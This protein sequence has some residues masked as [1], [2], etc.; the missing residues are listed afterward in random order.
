MAK[1]DYHY[2]VFKILTYLYSVI[3]REQSFDDMIFKK[4]I[5]TYD[6]K[7]EY[8]IDVLRM[9]SD[10]NLIKG[11]KFCNAWG[12]EFILLNDFC[13]MQISP[14]GIR[15][16]KE[17]KTMRKIRKALLS[18]TGIITELVKIVL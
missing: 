5:V 9:M 4:A 6:V 7:E 18:Q 1:D 2:I 11:L 13:D 12:N 16:L 8:L 15:Y 14:E 17:N 3:K 10:E